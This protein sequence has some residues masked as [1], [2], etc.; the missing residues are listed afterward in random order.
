MPELS[1][2]QVA[3]LV[4]GELLGPPDA[5]VNDIRSLERAGPSD[6]AF[7]RGEQEL[8]SA[9][10]SQAGVLIASERVESFGGSLVLCRDSQAAVARLLEVFAAERFP[11]PE[12]IGPGAFVADSARLGSGVAVGSGAQVGEDTVLEE[13]VV[14]FPGVSVGRHCRIGPRTVVHANASVHDRVEIG[15]DCIIHHNAVIGSEGFGFFQRQGRHVKFHQVGGVRLGDRVEVGALSTVD[16]GMVE[17]TVVGN[18]VKI[19]DHCHIAHNCRIGDNCIMAGYSKLAGSVVLG[20]GVIVAEDVG[21]TD[22]VSVGEGAILGAGSGV[23][24]D[25][26]PGEVLL[27]YPARPIADQR[28]IYALIG[29]LPQMARRLRNL[30]KKLADLAAADQPQ[31]DDA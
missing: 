2:A 18:G 13:G 29:R 11:R 25:V 16:R 6:I 14:I 20:E 30:E 22:H 26:K 9:A 28:R 12:G 7:A 21:V 8:E 15:A 1:A 23:H 4:E 3:E 24:A 31:Q 5:R 17:D 10:G 19:D 27:G